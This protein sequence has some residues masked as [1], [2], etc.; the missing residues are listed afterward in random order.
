LIIETI[1]KYTENFAEHN[2]K[3]SLPLPRNRK[4]IEIISLS[5]GVNEQFTPNP[6]L[7]NFVVIQCPNQYPSNLTS[8]SI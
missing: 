5:Y 4:K 6:N 8:K 7:F 1:V 2:A 3:N